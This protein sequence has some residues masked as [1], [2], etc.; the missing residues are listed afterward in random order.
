MQRQLAG[1]FDWMDICTGTMGVHGC[2][3]GCTGSCD[4]ST[5]PATPGLRASGAHVYT[6]V[7]ANH[8]TTELA[9]YYAIAGSVV[10]LKDITSVCGAHRCIWAGLRL[11]C[12]RR[13]DSAPIHPAYPLRYPSITINIHQRKAPT[14]PAHAVE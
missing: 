13:R 14:H 8:Y 3:W 6:L 2:A 10:A 1:G 4:Y 5:P 12:G 9:S 7:P 11:R